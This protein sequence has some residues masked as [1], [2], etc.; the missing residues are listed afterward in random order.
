MSRKVFFRLDRG[1]LREEDVSQIMNSSPIK[2]V[3]SEEDCYL[4]EFEA[5]VLDHALLLLGENPSRFGFDL[6]HY[7]LSAHGYFGR[8]VDGLLLMADGS[9]DFKRRFSED[10]GVATGSL[11]MVLTLEMRWETI[12]QIP[13]NKTLSKHAKTPDF[14]GF[15][16]SGQKRV[17]ECKGTTQPH[18]VD[19]FRQK[20]KQQLVEHREDGVTKYALVTYVPNAPRLI[21]PYLFLSDPPLEL[22]LL[23]ESMATG[24]HYLQVCKFAGFDNLH[25][26]L[27][28]ALVLLFALEQALSQGKPTSGIEADFNESL[29]RLL[30]LLE[31]IINGSTVFEFR[32]QKFIGTWREAQEKESKLRAFTGVNVEHIRAALTAVLI[33]PSSRTTF[34]AVRFQEES[35]K[36]S[37]REPVFSL[38]SDG[39][40]LWVEKVN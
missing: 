25:G 8:T 26:P 40:L 21:P 3:E 36:F 1:S 10:L 22:P 12:A 17:F 16:I 28:E 6:W 38:F 31:E 39:T 24:L 29:Q 33:S 23:T 15:D 2:T 11:L 37:E 13:I 27:R 35:I 30:A 34:R 18:Q 20:A 32:D 14:V 7:L 5:V 9:S 19:G 4:F